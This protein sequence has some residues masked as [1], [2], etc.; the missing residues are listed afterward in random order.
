MRLEKITGENVFY[1]WLLFMP[2]FIFIK[3]STLVIASE[4]SDFSKKWYDAIAY[5]IIFSGLTYI[6]YSVFNP[7]IPAYIFIIVGMVVV[8]FFSPFLIRWLRN[9]KFFRKYMLKPEVSA[10]D[11][12]FSSPQSYWVILHLRD[13]R[14]IGGVYS[15]KSFTSSFPY[16]QDIYLEE[17]WRL[18]EN[19]KF[20]DKIERSAGL[21]IVA[22][23]ISSIE[24]FVYEEE[25]SNEQ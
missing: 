23:E 8:P 1:V 12:I 20:A 7:Y 19:K 17:I 15:T 11:Y 4:V 21:W 3:S 13:G 25:H 16:K 22:E 10:W 24:F 6:A 9:R 14:N 2:G 5:G 18:D